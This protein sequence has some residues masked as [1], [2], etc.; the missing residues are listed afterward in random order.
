MDLASISPPTKITIPAPPQ[1]DEPSWRDKP[2]VRRHM[3][4]RTR[5]PDIG[6]TQAEKD[7]FGEEGAGIADVLD[8]LNPLQ[9]IPFVSTLYREL[10]GDTIST[11]SKIVGGALMGGP[12]GLVAAVFD[13]IFTQETGRGVG[14][15]ALAAITGD[16]SAPT[17]QV[18]Q[19]AKNTQFSEAQVVEELYPTEQAAAQTGPI[20]VRQMQQKM[21]AERYSSMANEQSSKH[22]EII[23]P[24]LTTSNITVPASSGNMSAAVQSKAMLD[25]YGQSPAPAHRAYRDANMLGYLREASAAG[26]NTVM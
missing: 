4:D 25:L 26:V 15:T 6:G 16:V 20:P 12:I 19:A 13:T 23:P 11:A 24:S 10:S 21:A 3:A 7:M 8:V 22:I 9:H 5:T 18:A 1:E 17:T 14:E 2:L